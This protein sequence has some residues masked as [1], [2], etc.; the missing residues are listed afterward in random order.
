VGWNGDRDKR[1]VNLN[2]ER[3]KM[4]NLIETAIQYQNLSYNEAEQYAFEGRMSAE[5]FDTWLALWTW[6]APR[7][8]G[9][10]GR[11]QDTYFKRYGQKAYERRIDRTREMCGLEPTYKDLPGH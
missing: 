10:A 11:I 6:S 9:A 4:N 8:S 7:F 1:E 2:W 3:D 5:I